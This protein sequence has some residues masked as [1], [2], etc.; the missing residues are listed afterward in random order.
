MK[1]SKLIFI[2]LID[3][4]GVV[5]YIILIAVI[6]NNGE[7]TFG[8][9]R[10]YL[11][12]IIFLLLFVIS[13]AITGALTLGRPVLLYLDNKKAEA[14]KL[15]FYTISWLILALLIVLVWQVC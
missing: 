7:K 2:G 15:F 6:L 14:I 9:M 10:N 1:N 4:L 3:A 8:L 5:V 12:P 11:G 13:A